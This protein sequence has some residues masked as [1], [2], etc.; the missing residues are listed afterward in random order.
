MTDGFYVLSNRGIR[1]NRPRRWP[2][3]IEETRRVP[4]DPRSAFDAFTHGLSDWWPRDYTWSQSALDAIW[5]EPAAGGRARQRDRGGAEQVWV[6]VEAAEP[7]A[8]LVLRWMI[9]PDRSA[10]ASPEQASRVSV[11]FRPDDGHCVVTLR[12]EEFERHR[13]DVYTYREGLASIQGWPWLM[14]LFAQHVR[15][16]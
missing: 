1:L 2:E 8:R 14:D 7:G 11:F 16:E 4:G 5:I 9:H 6:L 15:G 13:G 10:A 12:H 3:T